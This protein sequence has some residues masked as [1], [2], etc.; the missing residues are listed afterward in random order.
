MNFNDIK[1][2]ID[3]EFGPKENKKNKM[4]RELSTFSQAL[5]M[6]LD[7][8]KPVSVSIKFG[9][10]YDEV[11]KIYLQF[12]NLNRM[13]KLKQIYDELGGDM[14]PLISLYYKMQEN[15]FTF[16]QVEDAIN[17]VGSLS[18]LEEKHSVLSND[19]NALESRMQQL[20]S[21]NSQLSRQVE[22]A[23]NELSFYNNECKKKF[24]ELSVLNSEVNTKKEF[25]QDLDNDEGLV[26]IKEAAKKE[27][28]LILQNNRVLLAGTVMAVLEAI[29][30]YPANQELIFQL[31]VSGS[32][33]YGGEWIDYHKLELNQLSETIQKELAEKISKKTIEQIVG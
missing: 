12:L 1:E 13:N 32:E 3:R 27:S 23:E 17:L 24:E 30:L 5:K 22:L 18:E 2:I 16:K 15:N 7:G 9:L 8:A 25:I 11:R 21:S 20:T 14:R 4:K 19:V 33:L 29:R 10:G 6:F 26:R 31:L 28:E